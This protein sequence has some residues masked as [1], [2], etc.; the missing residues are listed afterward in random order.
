MATT[1]AAIA[2]EQRL[3][4]TDRVLAVLIQLAEL[5]DGSTL[6]EMVQL[7][8]HPKPT[9]HRAL[10]SLKRAGLAK[11]DGR[12]HYILGDEFLRLAFAH[13]EARPEHVR[14]RPLLERL[15][16]RFEETVHFAVLDGSDVVYRDKV[17]PSV[18]AVR[19]T[20]T[21]GGRNPAHSTGVGKALLATRLRTLDDVKA[22][23]QNRALEQRTANSATTVAEL[24]ARLVETRDR[25]F[26]VDD[27]ENEV[28][29]NCLAVPVYLGSPN[30]PSG[31]VSISAVAYRT[32]LSSL[33]AAADEIQTIICEM[34]GTRESAA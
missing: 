33:V 22:W 20:S 14:V 30:E 8:G 7:T 11:Q 16:E 18:G 31:A 4:G 9:I 25:G 5:P 27:Q 13:N 32:P 34:V 12:G 6:E 10:A 15:S 26:A 2:D 3:V 23:S 24:Y 29:I 28:G 21:I 19:L 1:P 17:D